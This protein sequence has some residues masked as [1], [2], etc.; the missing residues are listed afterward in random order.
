MASSSR[1]FGNHPDSYGPEP[2]LN[3]EEILAAVMDFVLGRTHSHSHSLLL[4][5]AVDIIV[6]TRSSTAIR[7]REIDLC[8]ATA[9]Q[10]AK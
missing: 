5:V 7:G 4:L 9:G 3:R 2:Q 6:A 8:V 10:A 1:S